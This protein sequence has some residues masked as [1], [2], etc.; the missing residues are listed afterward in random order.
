MAGLSDTY[1]RTDPTA[2]C[3]ALLMRGWRRDGREELLNASV[4]RLERHDRR[5]EPTRTVADARPIW[6][7]SHRQPTTF[8]LHQP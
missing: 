4:E 1:G 3:L 5:V 7:I 6:R 8:M 2:L